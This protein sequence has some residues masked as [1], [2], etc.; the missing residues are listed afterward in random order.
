MERVRRIYTHPLYQRQLMELKKAEQK[1]V[2]CKH[3]EAHF[4]A[5]ARLMYISCLENKIAFPKELIY[6]AAFLHDIGRAAQYRD[7]V[8]HEE[9]SVR[10]AGQIMRE[11]GFTDEET[12][13]VC[14]LIAAHRS[15]A[16][17]TDRKAPAVL[18]YEADKRS[19]NC[20]CCEA[21]DTCNWTP[22][23]RTNGIEI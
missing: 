6:A 2:Y 11:C 12:Q 13:L 17:E 23:Q 15:K 5:V 18:F 16:A 8:P 1:R 7:G 4:L 20:F 3:D 22:G 9:A 21:A 10:L 19:R 14:A